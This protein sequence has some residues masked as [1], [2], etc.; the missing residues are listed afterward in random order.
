MT[1]ESLKERLLQENDGDREAALEAVIG[2][3]L[4]MCQRASHGYSRM[5]NAY[6]NPRPL[7]A[8]QVPPV[9]LSSEK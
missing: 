6:A 2:A 8:R 4:Y 5:G 3:Y 9:L 7:K 1:P